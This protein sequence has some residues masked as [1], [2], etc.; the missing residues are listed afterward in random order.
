MLPS[1]QFPT[2]PLVKMVIVSVGD[3]DGGKVLG[4]VFNFARRRPEVRSNF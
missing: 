4:Q 3:D 1:V 2:G